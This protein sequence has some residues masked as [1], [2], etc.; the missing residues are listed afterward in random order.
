MGTY[1]LRIPA[2]AAKTKRQ[3]HSGST[4]TWG[5]ICRWNPKERPVEYVAASNLLDLLQGAQISWVDRQ[6]D[7]LTFQFLDGRRFHVIGEFDL[8]MEI[9]AEKMH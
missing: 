4:Y 1:R 3:S 7:G 2:A 8:A 5:C 6:K 9:R